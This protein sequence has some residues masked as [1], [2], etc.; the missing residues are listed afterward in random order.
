MT[1]QFSETTPGIHM[2]SWQ[3]PKSGAY[4][5]VVIIESLGSFTLYID[6]E[7]VASEIPTYEHA[8]NRAEMVLTFT[9]SRKMV[10][11]AGSLVLFAVVG[12]AAIGVSKLI[13]GIADFAPAAAWSAQALE[14]ITE[15]P[16]TERPGKTTI[17]VPSSAP[18][19]VMSTPPTIS[20]AIGT[21]PVKTA[22]QTRTPIVR[23]VPAADVQSQPFT[24]INAKASPVPRKQPRIFSAARPVFTNRPQRP[25]IQPAVKRVKV[26]T[27]NAPSSAY[28]PSK[29]ERVAIETTVPQIAKETQF[30]RTDGA[31][32]STEVASVERDSAPFEPELAPVPERNP[33]VIWENAE[34]KATMSNGETDSTIAATRPAQHSAGHASQPRKSRLSSS[35]RRSNRKRRATRKRRAKVAKS[36]ARRRAHRRFARRGPYRA[37]QCS[38]AG[39]RWVFEYRY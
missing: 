4:R 6:G 12:G 27:S 37:M 15:R 26:L 13:T 24:V 10:V 8:A 16:G 35:I 1:L 17:N 34:P 29:A 38:M 7:S 32:T 11:M 33:L 5:T 3:H 2:A 9:K 23:S 19:P 18:M 31:A 21:G 14:T 36:Y 30:S 28:A 39:C 20:G 22:A 25:T